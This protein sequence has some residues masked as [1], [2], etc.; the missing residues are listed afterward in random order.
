MNIEMIKSLLNNQNTALFRFDSVTSTNIIAKEKAPLLNNNAVFF[1]ETQT[2]GR[3]RFGH[4][5]ISPPE[6]GIY[7]SVVLKDVLKNVLK[8]LQNISFLTPAAAVAVCRAVTALTARKPEIKWV[9]D[10]L[11]G[12]R[13]LCGILSESAGNDAVIGIGINYTTDFSALP[14]LNAVSL[15][16]NNPTCTRE[17][18]AAFIINELENFKNDFKSCLKE[19]KALSCLTGQEISYVHNNETFF[20]TVIGIDDSARLLVKSKSGEITAL[21]SGE[22]MLIRAVNSDSIS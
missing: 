14:E 13:K 12:G 15:F 22:I 3:G 18:L 9:N 10:V 21:S 11:I 6:T 8:N 4:K 7:M 5:F 2:A 17:E 16:G 20:G 1:T 19:Y